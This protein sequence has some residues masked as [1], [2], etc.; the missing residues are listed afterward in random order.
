MPPAIS[1]LLP[2]QLGGNPV[3]PDESRRAQDPSA[4]RSVAAEFESLLVAQILRSFREAS[5]GGWSGSTE[6]QAGATMIELAEQQLA[7]ALTS[8]GGLGLADLIVQG[9]SPESNSSESAVDPSRSIAD[10]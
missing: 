1:D 5:E 3:R 4:L 8:K 9:L 7:R 6:D 2:G 10:K